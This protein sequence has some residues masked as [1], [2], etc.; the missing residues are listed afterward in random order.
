M[1]SQGFFTQVQRRL[2]VGSVLHNRGGGISTVKSCRGTK[3]SYLRGNSR[4]Y[5]DLYDFHHALRHSGG[6]IVNSSQLKT[7]KPS[8]FDSN[9]NGHSCNCTMF[10]M[11]LQAL[12]LVDRIRG[13]GKRSDP[14]AVSI[15]P[16]HH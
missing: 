1:E 13:T 10:F 12:G 11:I 3:M 16:L 7:Y 5:V 15:A 6:T 4:I 9:T 2:P 8:V 14:L